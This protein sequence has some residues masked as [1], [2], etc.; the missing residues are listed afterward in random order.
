MY[1][2]NKLTEFKPL[3]E[4]AN[5]TDKDKYFCAGVVFSPETENDHF[6]GCPPYIEIDE[7]DD[8]EG[9][10][11]VYFEVPEIVAYYAKEHAGYTMRGKDN[12]KEQGRQDMARKIKNLLDIQ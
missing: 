4:I 2:P 10:N 1:R 3:S 9:N 8:Y 11:T 7:V 5:Y 12:S 6:Q